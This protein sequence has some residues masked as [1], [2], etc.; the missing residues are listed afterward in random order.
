[1]SLCITGGT[2]IMPER[3]VTDAVVVC[4]NDKITYVGQS[5]KRIPKR[6]PSGDAN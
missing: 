2:A 5:K 1:M 6:E 3:T 4:R